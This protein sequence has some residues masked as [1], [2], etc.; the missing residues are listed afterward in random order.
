[1]KMSEKYSARLVRFASSQYTGQGSGLA[2]LLYLKKYNIEMDN[3][4]AIC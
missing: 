2:G 1:M 3:L 4:R